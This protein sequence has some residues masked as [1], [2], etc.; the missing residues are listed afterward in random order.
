MLFMW[1]SPSQRVRAIE[2]AKR[3]EHAR[4]S[5]PLHIRRVQA[6][7]RLGT[8]S[9]QA[10]TGAQKEARVVLNDLS[11]KGV[12]LY[13]PEQLPIGTKVIVN[14]Q[15]PEP[16]EIEA[17]VVWMQDASAS[18]SGIFADHAFKYRVG[19]VFQFKSPEEGEKLKKY[20]EEVLREYLYGKK[21]A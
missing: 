5:R 12:G 3:R 4:L 11:S 17:K 8:D 10:G 6:F 14:W 20:C 21:I 13:V 7:M 16:I 9:G 15:D 19:L 1:Q 2:S 18:S